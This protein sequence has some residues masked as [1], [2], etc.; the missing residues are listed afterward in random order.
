[1]NVLMFSPGY[2]VE[3]M[4]F[5]E[6]LARVGARVIGIG[7]PPAGAL[8]QR[9]RRALHDYIQVESLWDEAAVIDAV[10]RWG[11][12]GGQLDR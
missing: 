9:A 1:M 8:P 10:R 11:A 2:P 7:D 3:M 5:T 4:L 6:A 12:R